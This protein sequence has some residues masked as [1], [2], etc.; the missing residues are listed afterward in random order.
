VSKVVGVKSS[1][2]PRARV[3]AWHTRRRTYPNRR[4]PT[5]NFSSSFGTLGDRSEG[6]E[7]P[8]QEQLAL[9]LAPQTITR[10]FAMGSL[11]AADR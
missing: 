8:E 4:G 5:A 10:E 6:Q 9:K 3:I 11:V 1:N 7:Q 2:L